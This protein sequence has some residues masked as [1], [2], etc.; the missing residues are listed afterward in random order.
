MFDNSGKQNAQPENFDLPAEAV[1][2]LAGSQNFLG[3]IPQEVMQGV[4]SGDPKAFLA[5]IDMASKN[6]YAQAIRH[7]TKLTDAHLQGQQPL[8]T[9]QV[10]EIVRQTLAKQSA[11]TIPNST[12]PIVGAEI[13]RL[14][15]AY[16]TNNPDASPSDATKAAQEYIQELA[17]AIT[18][19]PA[20]TGQEDS[21]V[22]YDKFFR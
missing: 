20:A 5:A 4:Q 12:N 6:A 2:K 8:H 16:L 19:T 3:G 9:K 14:A 17:R 7:T 1:D 21:Q 18:G 15:Q 10:E 11:S 13:N 22:D